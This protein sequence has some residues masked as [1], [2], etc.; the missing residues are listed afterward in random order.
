MKIFL[1]TYLQNVGLIIYWS[2][3]KSRSIEVTIWFS[4]RAALVIARFF[5]KFMLSAQSPVLFI[6]LSG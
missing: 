4:S 5:G 1:P 6:A 2:L 3:D